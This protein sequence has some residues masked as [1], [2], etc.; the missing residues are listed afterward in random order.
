MTGNS[1]SQIYTHIIVY[2][3]NNLHTKLFIAALF[4]SKDWL[5]PKCAS[6]GH[7]L[8][9]GTSIQWTTL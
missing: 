7:Y 1:T 4:K 8:N 2:V 9:C 5:Q 6:I 3:Q